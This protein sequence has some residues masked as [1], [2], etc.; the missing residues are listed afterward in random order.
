[1]IERQSLSTCTSF[2]SSRYNRRIHT[3][4]K[5][6]PGREEREKAVETS[7]FSRQRG[8]RLVADTEKLDEAARG[9]V[10]QELVDLYLV[11]HQPTLAVRGGNV[12]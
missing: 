9:D 12:S 3:S 11:A 2:E 7:G 1:M 4:L 5:R 10:R 8:A 6:G